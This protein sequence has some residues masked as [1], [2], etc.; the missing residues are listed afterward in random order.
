MDPLSPFVSFL[1]E[2][3]EVVAAVALT[4]AGVVVLVVIAVV[5]AKRSRRAPAP[6]R[7]EGG[8][9]VQITVVN[10]VRARDVT[11][12]PVQRSGSDD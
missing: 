7:N 10:D 1:L 12:S 4:L 5:K 9:N 6:V 3:G 2:R 11:V 8:R